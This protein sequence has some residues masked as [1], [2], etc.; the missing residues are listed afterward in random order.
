M[1]SL[2]RQFNKNYRRGMFEK[3]K[4]KINYLLNNYSY[5]GFNI[6]LATDRL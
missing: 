3:P 4:T 1:P 5:R 6:S 2:F